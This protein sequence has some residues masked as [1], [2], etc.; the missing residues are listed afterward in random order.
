VKNIVRMAYLYTG[1]GMLGG[2]FYREYTK[3]MDFDGSTVLSVVHT[4]LLSMGMLFMLVLLALT[5]L[6]PLISNK[7]FKR[8]FILYNVAFIETVSML[9]VR[10]VVQ[11]SV[12][13]LSSSTDGMI[14]GMAGIGHIGI[15][16]SLV[17]L[18]MSLTKVVNDSREN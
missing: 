7:W 14:A 2:L 5:K 15:G 1:A 16:V 3:V 12:N 10:G 6:F 8:F 18:F 17:F 13:D 11:V 9:I 4:H